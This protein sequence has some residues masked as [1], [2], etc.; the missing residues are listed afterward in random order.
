MV[1]TFLAQSENIARPHSR[2]P[3]LRGAAIIGAIVASLVASLDR[4]AAQETRA[5]AIRQEQAEKRQALAPPQPNGVER[6]I[7]R[8]EDW[9]LIAG[10]PRG[11]YPWFGSVY[12]GGGF[13]AGAGV[14]KPF[15]DDGAFN[16]FGGYSIATF[17]RAQADLA[18]PTFAR[19]HARI[20]LSGQYIDAP[21]VRYFGVGNSS[22]KDDATRFG[23]TPKGGGARLDIDAGKH[24]SL[25]GGVNYTDIETSGG[26][27]T[28][29]IE[30]RFTPVNT[31]GLG[32]SNF[33]YINT[34]AQA[35]FDWRR[36]LGYSGRG[37]LYR[38]AFDDYREQDNDLYSFQSVEA[39]VLQLIPILRANWVIALRGLATLTDI[40]ETSI[41]PF[42]M[43]PSL[44]GGSTLRGY[45]DFRFRDRN[46]LVMNAE[47]RWTPARFMDMAIFYDTGKVTAR[48]EDLDFDDLKES[49]G[50]G[51]RIIGLEGYALRIE[52]ARSR[53]NNARLIFSAGG[54]F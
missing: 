42:F 33:T 17:A 15:A 13:A 53:E 23:Y 6:F 28:P 39:E 52:V 29:S 34:T 25:G 22:N 45:P 2:A 36:P 14:R 21:D 10:E 18:L 26:R 19:N 31:P 32:I 49:Y 4:A 54:G 12:P 7:D 51:M 11:L 16:V 1:D 40:D 24:F 38:V 46:R 30:E 9:G 27:T 48:R 43:L 5:E 37:G 44:G 8:L 41:V 35:A 20:T 47:L 3:R 50:I